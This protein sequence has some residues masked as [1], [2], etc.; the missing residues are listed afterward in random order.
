[1]ALN[2]RPIFLVCLLTAFSGVTNAQP[3]AQLG[4]AFAVLGLAAGQTMRIN[5]LNLGSRVSTPTSSCEV[6]MR[7]LD[8]KGTVVKDSTATI[9]N[10]NSVMLDLEFDQASG[11]N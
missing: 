8:A 1:M 2:F 10:G 3:S 6:T 9:V 4:S 5:A 11:T 7:F